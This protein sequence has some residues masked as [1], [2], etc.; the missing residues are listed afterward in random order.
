MIQLEL[1]ERGIKDKVKIESAA[2]KRLVGDLQTKLIEFQEEERK[3]VGRF[4]E[5]LVDL[6]TQSATQQSTF[7][8]A[9]G[10]RENAWNTQLDGAKIEL[11]RLQDTYD[12][13]MSLAAPVKYWESKQKRHGRWMIGSGLILVVSMVSSGWFLHTEIDSIGR[14]AAVRKAESATQSASGMTKPD[15]APSG[16]PVSVVS[17]VSTT[18]TIGDAIEAAAPWRLGSFILLA[19]LCFW[20]LRLLV[21]I[22]LSNMHLENDA[23]ERVTMAKTYLALLRK[24]RLPDK[25]DISM[26]LQAL[27]R[28]AGD[29]IVKDEGV[30]PTTLEWVTKLGK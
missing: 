13:Y 14:A 1:F 17:N 15:S 26:V 28:P 27:F 16:A 30:P 10:D 29:G 20:V 9:Q 18:A 25:E 23:S 8:S 6:K 4:N 3:Q 11:K 21:R 19:T 12:N 2:L 5:T 22:F 7:D 24:G